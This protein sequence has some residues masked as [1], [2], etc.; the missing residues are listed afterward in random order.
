[1]R[2]FTLISFVLVTLTIS[3]NVNG[4]ELSTPSAASTTNETNQLGDWGGN[5]PISV[6]SNDV[7]DGNYALK[8]RAPASGWYQGLYR[9]NT[10]P[11][12][13]YDVELWAK[14][15]NPSV[16]KGLWNW[17]GFENFGP[18]AKDVMSNQWEKYTF[19]VTATGNEGVIKV[20]TG[21]P[22]EPGDELLIDA[23]SI[24]PYPDSTPPTP[25][26]NTVIS[27]TS[28]FYYGVNVG[29]E[30]MQF[31]G[32]TL[33][34]DVASFGGCLYSNSAVPAPYNTERY[35]CDTREL[36]FSIDVPNGDY[37][38]KLHFAELY[39]DGVGRRV[40]NTYLEGNIVLQNY[41]IH[42]K[43]GFTS[44]VIEEFDVTV[45]DG[46]LDVFLTTKESGYKDVPKLGAIEIF[47]Q[48]QS[49]DNS[50]NNTITSSPEEMGLVWK[51]FNSISGNEIS[52]LTAH[53]NYP[54]NPD[55]VRIISNFETPRLDENYGS[56]IEGYIVAPETGNYRF[57]IST[58]DNGE[59]YLSSSESSLGLLK[60]ADVPGYTDPKGWD[61]YPS[62]K[63]SLIFL[64]AGK[65][66]RV[67]ALHKEGIGGDWLYVGWRKPSDGDG[68][69]PVEVIPNA[70]LRVT[71][72][73]SNNSGSNTN[74]DNNTTN[75]SST[76]QS[77]D[78]SD[79]NATDNTNSSGNDG[80]AN[81]TTTA[82][83]STIWTKTN[84]IASYSNQVAIGRNN[85]PAG[86]QL[87]VQG[88]IITDEVRVE[89][90]QNWPDYVF[91]SDYQMRSIE[92][93]KNYIKNN[94]HL[95]N[96]PSAQVI[97]NKGYELGDMNKKLLEK[98][99]EITL[100]IIQLKSEIEG[101]KSEYKN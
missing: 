36:D 70:S 46:K 88:K 101:L 95:P 30:Q 48:N 17:S 13:Q 16:K 72:E 31:N 29:G 84:N 59:L 2:Y 3:L 9:I 91:E 61:K 90:V 43:V 58:D 89:L 25:D 28:N 6:E 21:H 66:Y 8:L 92:E 26:S 49:I 60:I 10:T 42:S 82:S 34:A 83:G 22:S 68:I 35:G 11:G 40:F 45:S 4:Q 80:S 57:W 96:I 56:L 93:L 27:A 67:R 52:K 77:S 32:R 98:I 63:S 99:E 97:Q 38:V 33:Q 78:A 76:N 79:A 69:A 55:E 54:N 73:G 65:Y 64:E 81:D 24:R 75:D 71:N 7:Y 47:G 41:D 85:V 39:H 15:P 50:S 51:K 44:P 23:F 18:L 62:Q 12:Q 20:Y 1:M 87:A 53:P 100:Y 5:I 86:F 19:R 14:N 94:G 37:R 74:G